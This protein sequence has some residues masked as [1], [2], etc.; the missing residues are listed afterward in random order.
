MLTESSWT[1]SLKTEK[2]VFL[3]WAYL[4]KKKKERIKQKS[5]GLTLVY[6]SEVDK[7]FCPLLF[8]LSVHW[9]TAFS[10]QHKVSLNLKMDGLL[11][12][13]SSPIKDSKSSSPTNKEKLLVFP[14]DLQDKL[15]Q[16]SIRALTWRF[17]LVDVQI[18]YG[19]SKNSAKVGKL[20]V[21]KA[22]Q[23][24]PQVVCTSI[25]QNQN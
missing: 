20:C 2:D 3:V 9:N 13:N 12:T 19:H 14:W 6:V 17:V 22:I 5:N 10:H 1:S 21:V 23:Q 24:R 4:K 18:W 16:M 15:M 7:P 11:V 25:L 8:V